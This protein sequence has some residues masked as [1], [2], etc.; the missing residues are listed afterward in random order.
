ML[1]LMGSGKT[2]IGRLVAEE[3]GRPLID[4]DVWLEERNGGRTAADIAD[5]HGIEALH[6]L[7]AEV[8]LDALASSEPAVIGP[9]ASVIENARVRDA[10][11]G[12]AVVWLEATAE[13]LAGHAVR[14]THRPLLDGGDPVELFRRQLAVREPLVLALDPLV[15][16]VVNQN[17]AQ[18]VAMIVDYVRGVTPTAT[19]SSSPPPSS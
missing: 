5:E 7:E 16:D 15:V 8:A 2:S 6:A 19:P 1:G 12:H 11:A 13:Y 3:L 17:K 4:G 18:E 14:K 10:L 9:A